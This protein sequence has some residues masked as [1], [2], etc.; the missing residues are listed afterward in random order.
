MSQKTNNNLE[1]PEHIK[2]Q[3]WFEVM[4]QEVIPTAATRKKAEKRF[5]QMRKYELDPVS[6]GEEVLGETY[7]QE[8]QDVMRSVRDNPITIAR[9]ANA[10]GK[11]HGAA[12]MVIW[13]FTVFEDAKVFVTAAP[14]IDNLKRILWG[15]IMSIVENNE[16]FFDG[17]TLRSLKISRSANS[18]ID[19]VAIPTSGTEEQREAKFSGKHAPHLLFVVDEGDAVPDEVYKGIES[20]MS[21]GVA[22]MLIMFNPRSPTGPVYLKEKNGLANVVHLSAFTHPNVVTGKDVYPGAVDRETTVRRINQWTRELRP[23][24][25]ENEN[26]FEVPD[27]LV[28]YSATA[29]D[30][31]KYPPLPIGTRVIVDPEFAYMVLGLYPPQGEA[32]LINRAWVEDAQA[33]WKIYVEQNGEVP[34]AVQPILAIDV[35]ELGVDYNAACRRYTGFVPRM[36][37][38]SGVDTDETA[39]RARVLYNKYNARILYVDG[40][41]VGSS[42][43]PASVRMERNENP[44]TEMRAVT[45]KVAGRATPGSAV[46]QGEFYQLRDQLWW[47]CREW[48]R[49]DPTAMLPPDPYLA[50]ELCIATYSIPPQHGRIKILGKDNMRDLL[51]R[52]PNRADALCLTFMPEQIAKVVKVVGSKEEEG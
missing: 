22:R 18:F 52:S 48:L 19:C 5:A 37:F 29:L 10:T 6:F 41:G 4:M 46:E 1:I 36:D 42:V 35:A 24:E 34:P 44:R 27:F 25:K 11:S 49:T 7:T 17:F 13:F 16:E 2:N 51:K 30:G 33:R 39:Q 38:W 47:T 14:P 12:R 21:G 15:E 20:C 3:Q 43:A 50:D 28:G 32:Q 45:V 9:S 26:C 8:V 31:K 23:E 40:T